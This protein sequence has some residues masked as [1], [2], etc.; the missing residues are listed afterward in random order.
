MKEATMVQEKALYLSDLLTGLIAGL[1]LRRIS[2][3]SIN[4][5]FASTIARWLGVPGR[6]IRGSRAVL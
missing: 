3:L 6:P 2:A 4:R 1:A 5:M